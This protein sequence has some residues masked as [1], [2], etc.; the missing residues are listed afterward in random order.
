MKLV[1]SAVHQNDIILSL[2]T[3]VISILLR[4]KLICLIR[5]EL[6]GQKRVT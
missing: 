5:L 6:T 4:D 1:Y 3:L 2:R